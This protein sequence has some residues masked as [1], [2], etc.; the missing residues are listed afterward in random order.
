MNNVPPLPPTSQTHG[1]TGTMEQFAHVAALGLPLP[2]AL[3]ACAGESSSP[4]EARELRLLANKVEAGAS[5]D[6]ALREI[7]PRGRAV[8]ALIAAGLKTGRLP[9]IL[10]AYLNAERHTRELWQRFWHSL[11]YPMIVTIAALAILLG[12]MVI[13]IPQFKDIFT[14]F[15]LELPSLT[16]LLIM[17]SD[18]LAAAWPVYAVMLLAALML[19]FLL[20]RLPVATW[21]EYVPIVGKAATKAG[22]SEFCALL[23]VC[24][25][26][27]MPLPEALEAIA[28]S[29]RSGRVRQMSGVMSRRIADGLDPQLAADD[30]DFPQDVR[31]VFRWSSSRDEFVTLLRNHAL[32]LAAE[33]R[34]QVALIGFFL[35]PFVIVFLAVGVGL[36]VISLFM[37]LVRLLNELS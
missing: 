25:E 27:D 12:A 18:A 31:H 13:I 7:S 30:S 23:S 10:E 32:A 14:D 2:A 29:S 19:I 5:L 4:T 16:M 3:Y 17:I 20:P 8:W 33:S 28:S 35:Q 24:V 15:G 37:P 34:V 22:M 36:I 26:S 11:L 21:W 9:R 1:S 6:S